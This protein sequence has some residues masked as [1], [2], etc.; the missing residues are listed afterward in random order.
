MN[1]GATRIKTVAVCDSQPVAVEGI[2]AILNPC[3]DLQLIGSS[4]SLLAGMEMVRAHPPSVLLI[5]KAFGLQPVMDWIAGLRMSGCRSAPVVWGMSLSEAEALRIMQAG[6]QGVMLKTTDLNGLLGCLRR[7]A[8]GSHW[9][10]AGIFQDWQALRCTRSSLTPREQ[11]VVELVEQGMKNKE[12]ARV[13]GICPGTVKIHLKHIFE[14]TGVR[15]RYG[16]ALSG[17]R[18]KGLLSLPAA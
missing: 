6:A 16:L 15:G 12:I 11:Q 17:L 3:P 7:V 18:E 9:M 13:L 5:D 14:K 10:E 1:S 4:G 8:S 2:R